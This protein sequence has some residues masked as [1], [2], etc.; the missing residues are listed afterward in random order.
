M[1]KNR[2]REGL[3]VLRAHAADT[4]LF[5]TDALKPERE[6]AVC[7]AFLRC[8]GV[9]FDQ[10]EIVASVDE[11]VDVSFREA[12]FQVREVLEVGRRRG[13]EWRKRAECWNRARSLGD[14]VVSWSPPAPLPLVDLIGSLPGALEAKVRKY[15]RQCSTLDA[16]VYVNLRS[17]F[18]DP[19]ISQADTSS[20]ETQ[21]WRSVSILF[22]PYGMVLTA[23]DDAPDFLR[24]WV[25][26]AL[27]QWNRLDDLFDTEGI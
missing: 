12:C 20:L 15:G 23:G 11:P 9:P 1:M 7:R 25:G 19:G 6:R 4:R 13:D 22:P 2:E 3:E 10:L 16:L 27:R 24:S 8:V 17:R 18:L 5:L 21:G 14:T 26:R